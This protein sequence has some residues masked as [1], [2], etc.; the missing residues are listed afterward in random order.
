MLSEKQKF[1]KRKSNKAT[2]YEISHIHY[3]ADK[4]KCRKQGVT[5]EQEIVLYIFLDSWPLLFNET[6]TNGKFF[7]N[8]N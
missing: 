4:E 7:A 2:I 3:Y 1:W 5:I 8:A 6:H